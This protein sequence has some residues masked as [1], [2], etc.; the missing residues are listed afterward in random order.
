MYKEENFKEKDLVKRCIIVERTRSKWLI[1]YE[2]GLWKKNK[3][4]ERI[5][6]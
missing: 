3:T 4:C 2:H 5:F 1:T 6:K